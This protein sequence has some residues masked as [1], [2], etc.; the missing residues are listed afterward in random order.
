MITYTWGNAEQTVL[1]RSDG[2][3]IPV[4]EGNRH[5]KQFLESGSSVDPYVAPP[6][7]PEPTPEEKLAAAGLTVEELRSLLA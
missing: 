1:A 2:L 4:D 3:F 6:A 5:Y 7:P